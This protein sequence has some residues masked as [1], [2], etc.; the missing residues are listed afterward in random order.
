MP[1]VP[2]GLKGWLQGA[3]CPGASES[4]LDFGPTVPKGLKGAH[5]GPRSVI[6]AM[7]LS[8]VFGGLSS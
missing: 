2:K 3:S 1:V 6:I 5:R 8:G 4:S 7:A